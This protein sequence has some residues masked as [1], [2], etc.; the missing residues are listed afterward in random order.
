[1][2]KKL[3]TIDWL[4]DTLI[5]DERYHEK[6]YVSRYVE[7]SDAHCALRYGVTFSDLN[8]IIK[9]LYREACDRYCEPQVDIDSVVLSFEPDSDTQW[10]YSDY[11]SSAT[12]NIRFNWYRLE[13][14]EEF[15]DRQDRLNRKKRKAAQARKEKA[16]KS[17]AERLERWNTYIELKKEF[18]NEFENK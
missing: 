7:V 12:L 8:E 10:N 3:A 13:S 17:E 6:I 9:S 1:M 16:E 11:S 2:I 4:G 15:A 14:N 18:E 5:V